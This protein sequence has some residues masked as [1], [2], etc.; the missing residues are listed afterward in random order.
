MEMGE[1]GAESAGQRRY[2]W[3]RGQD[4]RDYAAEVSLGALVVIL[5]AQGHVT[6]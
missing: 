5:R 6:C 1:L 2:R 4:K 3:F